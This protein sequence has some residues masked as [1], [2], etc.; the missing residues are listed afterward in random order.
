MPCLLL[1]AIL[2]FPR[3]VLAVLFFFSNYLGA[4]LSRAPAA[5]AGLPVPAADNFDLRLDGEFG[6][7]LGR[8][9]SFDPDPGGGHRRRRSWRRLSSQQAMSYFNLLSLK[10]ATSRERSG[11]ADPPFLRVADNLI[12]TH[13]ELQH[14]RL[15]NLQALQ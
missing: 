3:L 7:A 2:A 1:I 6:N 9:E 8:G 10:T 4:R 12:G 14:R 5:L 15:P 11:S 13:L